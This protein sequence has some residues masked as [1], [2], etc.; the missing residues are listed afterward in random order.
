MAPGSSVCTGAR[1]LCRFRSGQSRSWHSDRFQQTHLQQPRHKSPSPLACLSH[2]FDYSNRHS[3]RMTPDFRAVVSAGLIIGAAYFLFKQLG[4]SPKT[5]S[6]AKS[7]KTLEP[8]DDNAAIQ[9][10]LRQRERIA[11][12]RLAA[13]AQ[14]SKTRNP[15]YAETDRKPAVDTTTVEQQ[16]LHCGSAGTTQVPDKDDGYEDITDP[17]EDRRKR[18]KRYS[19]WA[20]QFRTQR[21]AEAI[22]QRR[23]NLRRELER[24]AKSGA[25]AR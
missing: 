5:G 7:P 3:N 24:M 13:P 15:V 9:D 12:R 11:A 20:G 6:R 23:D 21:R 14:R 4:P 17:E 16:T 25:E 19:H 1:I 2:H 8:K 22:L 18:P 10:L